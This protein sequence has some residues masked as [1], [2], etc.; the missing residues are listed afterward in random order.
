MKKFFRPFALLLVCVL[1]ALSLCSCHALDEA[2][3]NRGLYSEDRTEIEY[4]GYTYR[5]LDL[6][7]TILIEDM[8]MGGYADKTA[9]TITEKDVPI[10]L[11]E[12][13]GETLYI[14]EDD[15]VITTYASYTDVMNDYFDNSKL[16]V[17]A[18]YEKILS[19]IENDVKRYIREDKYQ[20]AKAFVETGTAQ[21]FY[22][23]DDE[24]DYANIDY[25]SID[26]SDSEADVNDL[27]D[28]KNV[29]V[30]ETLSKACISAM[31]ASENDKISYKEL[32]RT[33]DT[34]WIYPCDSEML[35]TGNTMEYFNY[36]LVKDKD[37]YYFW[38]GNSKQD[39]SFYPLK[40][41]A[42]DEAIQLFEKYPRAASDMESQYLVSMNYDELSGFADSDSLEV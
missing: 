38:D 24:T 35:L 33:V 1:L 21:R 28:I 5:L 17:N 29:A 37:Q 41:T 2:R 27:F 3:A 32:S 9:C 26:S 8:A 12:Q 19:T 30:P 25:G 13:Y 31:K 39:K 23:S 15:T 20:A 16:D 36:M 22:F 42:A 18:D 40:D 14:N 7:D 4:K 10:L 6:G 34:I 11:A